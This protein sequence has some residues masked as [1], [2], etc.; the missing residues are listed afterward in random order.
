MSFDLD[1]AAPLRN[2]RPDG[3]VPTID[4]SPT[5]DPAGNTLVYLPLVQR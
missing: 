3:D 2:E 4:A 1:S 5:D